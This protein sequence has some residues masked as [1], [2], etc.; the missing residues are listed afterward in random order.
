MGV[1]R[2]RVECDRRRWGLRPRGRLSAPSPGGC[3]GRRRGVRAQ[4]ATAPDLN[5]DACGDEEQRS[6]AP[7]AEHGG[8]A[9]PDRERPE[10]AG[11]GHEGVHLGE[12]GVR[13]GTLPLQEERVDVD[14]DHRAAE[15]SG[16]QGDEAEAEVRG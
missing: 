5:R 2:G 12:C 14:D 10:Q 8:G 1:I 3:G 7:A 6:A 13:S 11:E 4:V 9:E 15:A 16:E